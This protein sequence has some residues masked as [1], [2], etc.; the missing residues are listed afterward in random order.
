M[1]RIGHIGH[2]FGAKLVFANYLFSRN[3][4]PP[5][6][7]LL[8]VKWTLTRRAKKVSHLP[9]YCRIWAAISPGGV[10]YEIGSLASGGM[11]AVAG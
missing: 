9:K 3:H 10:T 1:F 6:V 4:L 2:F 11:L 8:G 5:K 7:L